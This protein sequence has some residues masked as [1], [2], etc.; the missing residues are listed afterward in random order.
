MDGKASQ[1]GYQRLREIMTE[2]IIAIKSEVPSDLDLDSDNDGNI[3]GL[4][5]IIQGTPGVGWAAGPTWPHQA[6]ASSI[7]ETIN[8]KRVREYNLMN[9]VSGKSI[10]IHEF[11]HILGSPDLYTHPNNN[12]TAVGN[13]DAMG[14][15]AATVEFLMHLRHKYFNWIDTIP[16]ITQSGTYTLNPTTSATNNVYR[17][18]SPYRYCS[19][20]EYFLVE[21][22]KK[23]SG[24]FNAN[25][26][27]NNGLLITRINSNHRGNMTATKGNYEVYIYRPNGTQTTNGTIA[28]AAYSNEYQRTAINENTNPNGF[29]KNGSDGGLDISN[30]KINPDSTISFTVNIIVPT[31]PTEL[32]F[33]TVTVAINF[34][35]AKGGS[36]GFRVKKII[37]VICK[38]IKN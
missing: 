29:L 6:S 4:T 2:A 30:I 22:R 23:N 9:E 11:A 38:P 31:S 10:T 21:Y 26:S 24:K 20:N 36:T 3:D 13:W 32:T 17:I 18:N 14:D 28:E 19:G 33:S 1:I 37:L 5:I 12:E 27:Q 16:V 34:T 15:N 25:Y 35:G 7:T 8:G